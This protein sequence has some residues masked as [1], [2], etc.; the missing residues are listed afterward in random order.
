MADNRNRTLRT[1]V[2]AIDE[3]KAD[4]DGPTIPWSVLTVVNRLVATTEIAFVAMDY[5]QRRFTSHQVLEESVRL[6]VDDTDAAHQ[7]W[8]S[9]AAAARTAVNPRLSTTG[10]V[11]RWTAEF[12]ET[13]IRSWPLYQEYWRGV[14][15]LLW[16]EFPAA[17]GQTRRL[18]LW[19]D[20][21]EKFSA[22]DEALVRLLQPHLFEIDRLARRRSNGS[23][24]LTVREWQVLELVAQGA[25][26]AEVAA[27]LVTSVATVRKHMEHIFD[28]SGVRS[29]SAA[30]AR[31]MPAR[32]AHETSLLRS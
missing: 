25:S 11:E 8:W 15:D 5:R 27:A 24:G 12:D 32:G 4:L 22:G 29:R 28:R 21:P 2:D 9:M 19:R 18:L 23:P 3:M 7:Q 13:Q 10:R 1:M 26:N 14:G 31:L 6:F 17:P 16:I 20:A 30:V